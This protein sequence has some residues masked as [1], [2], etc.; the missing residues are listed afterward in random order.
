MNIVSQDS[1]PGKIGEVVANAFK[2]LKNDI[3]K[4]SE[5]FKKYIEEEGKSLSKEAEYYV[6]DIK[7][8][9]TEIDRYVLWRLLLCCSSRVSESFCRSI[10]KTV[11]SYSPPR[12]FPLIQN[13][14][15]LG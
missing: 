14:C 10:N 12:R 7:V 2:N 6:A 8:D 9:Q 4:F 3:E 11:H 1:H 13:F 5:D 15:F